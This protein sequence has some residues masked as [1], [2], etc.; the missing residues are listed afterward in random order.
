MGDGQDVIVETSSNA[1]YTDTLKCGAGITSDQIW[2]RH[3]GNSLEVSVIGTSDKV[4]IS[5]WYSDSA[6]HLEQLKTAD[7]KTLLDSQVDSLVQAMASF[8]PP[9]A[10]QMTLPPAYQTA[11]APVL[12]ANWK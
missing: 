11:L 4:T 1:S 9:A 8:A 12:A 2:L 7:G 6:Y 3:T 10:G 5:N